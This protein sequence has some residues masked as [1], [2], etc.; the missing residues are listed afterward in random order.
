MTASRSWQE[1]LTHRLAQGLTRVPPSV[2]A[3]LGGPPRVV[4]GQSLDP[5]LAA[6]LALQ[7]RRESH[8]PA[9]RSPEAR[10]A[11]LAATTRILAGPPDPVGGSR[12]VVVD[13]AQGPLRAR[14]YRPPASV[15]GGPRPLVVFLHGGGWVV[16]DLD[17]HDRPCRLLCRYADAHV[18][19]IEYRL[20]PEHPYPAALDDAVAA[21]GWAVAHAE[22]MG[23]DPSRV[24]VAGDSA[25]GNLAAVLA[26]VTRDEGL[27]TP[28]AQLLVYPGCDASVERPS[29][30]L[31]AD[32]YFLTR[33][34]MDWYWATYTAGGSRTDP[35]LSP[36]CAEDLSG[37]APA[38]VSTAGFDPLRDEGED[39]ARALREAGV[40][41]VMRRASSLVHGFLNLADVHPASRDESVAVA[42]AFGA[43]LD[44]G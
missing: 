13:G 39:Y 34:Q 2:T 6:V 32:G 24:A 23:A 21:F 12:D 33:S 28:C 8:D 35:R 10:R 31:F 44:A 30:R 37:L 38:V 18:L 29:K 4:D 25:G 36:W 26:Q 5:H 7:R 1:T 14:H 15:E 20:A 17:T 42:A 16:G 22:E 41:V 43:L 40:P 9:D 27:T 19:A 3:R 11:A